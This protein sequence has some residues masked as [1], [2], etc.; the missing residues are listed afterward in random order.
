MSCVESVVTLP[1]E[2]AFTVHCF[3]Q[4]ATAFYIYSSDNKL[5]NSHRSMFLSCLDGC[6]TFFLCWLI[7]AKQV[8]Y[9]L[10]Q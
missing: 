2:E 1:S 3:L 7:Y 6:F 9:F 4:L 8:F 5:H 10:I